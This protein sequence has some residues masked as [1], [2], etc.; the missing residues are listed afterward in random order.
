MKVI[1]EQIFI[2]EENN[3]QVHINLDFVF[4]V[5]PSED[6]EQAAFSFMANTIKNKIDGNI[7]RDIQASSQVVITKS[8]EV[9]QNPP[10]QME[11][12]AQIT[13]PIENVEVSTQQVNS[14]EFLPLSVSEQIVYD[15]IKNPAPEGKKSDI[16]WRWPATKPIATEIAT[17]I[18]CKAHGE[19]RVGR[20]SYT[21][22]INP[23]GKP[24]FWISHSKKVEGLFCEEDIGVDKLVELFDAIA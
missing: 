20:Y 16:I 8:D 2:E 21:T 24:N 22:R 1:K 4:Y 6:T 12:T 23:S 7:R 13:T 14:E 5:T 18:N 19:P 15:Y 10:I 17:F 3:G 9:L 11:H